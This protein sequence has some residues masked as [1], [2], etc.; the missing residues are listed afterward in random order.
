MNKIPSEKVFKQSPSPNVLNIMTKHGGKSV[1]LV[2]F[3]RQI[4]EQHENAVYFT[5]NGVHPNIPHTFPIATEFP[6]ANP[7]VLIVYI[8]GQAVAC[9]EGYNTV[10]REDSKDERFWLGPTT[11]CIEK[12]HMLPDPKYQTD[13]RCSQLVTMFIKLVWEEVKFNKVFIKNAD[14]CKIKNLK[15]VIKGK[16]LKLITANSKILY[17]VR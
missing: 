8:K 1:P 2:G 6:D 17:Q 4:K 5:T 12:I 11:L 3:L 15:S 10:L 16:H 13:S 9:V 14:F 7:Y